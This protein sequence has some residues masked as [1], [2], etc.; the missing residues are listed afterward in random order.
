M[1]DLADGVDDDAKQFIVQ[2]ARKLR[3]GKYQMRPALK[4]LFR[5]AHFYAPANVGAQ[6]KSPVHLAVGT[7]RKLGLSQVPGV[8]DF[9]DTTAELGQQL[10][11]PPTVAGWAQGR[12]WITP[13]L[14]MA[15]GNFGYD[16]L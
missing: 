2:W 16:V 4:S 3:E 7:Y 10:F 6:I 8:P 12:S 1:S 11:R 13:G 5:S 9:N 14:L 15:R